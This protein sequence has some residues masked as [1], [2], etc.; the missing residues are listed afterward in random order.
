MI[1]SQFPSRSF[2][3]ILTDETSLKR[4]TSDSLCARNWTGLLFCCLLSHITYCRQSEVDVGHCAA[5][6]HV[7]EQWLNIGCSH[8]EEEDRAC[9]VWQ[10]VRQEAG[11]VESRYSRHHT[12]YLHAL[13]SVLD[14]NTE[15]Q[16]FV[17]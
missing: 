11:S 1:W 3:V 17:I 13:Q 8:S 15:T 2:G 16:G 10:Q 12:V 9:Y 7:S 4:V 6:Y 5:L 14:W